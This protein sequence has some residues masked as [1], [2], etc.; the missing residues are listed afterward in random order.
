M[1]KWFEWFWLNLTRVGNNA[2]FVNAG[3]DVRY[4]PFGISS[5]IQRHLSFKAPWQYVPGI[6]IG[7]FPPF[8]VINTPLSRSGKRYLL[9]R[10]GW[11]YDYG[12]PGYIFEAATKILDHVTIY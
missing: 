7:I 3:D 10:A 9:L 8:I 1:I 12:W 5:W 6:F 4:D 11:R 2:N